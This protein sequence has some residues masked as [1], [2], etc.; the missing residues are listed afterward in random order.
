MY[1]YEL[2]KQNGRTAVKK[3]E[4]VSDLW[5]THRVWCHHHCCQLSVWQMSKFVFLRC[6]T[7]QS[8]IHWRPGCDAATER[9]GSPLQQVHTHTHTLWGKV[10]SQAGNQKLSLSRYFSDK[11]VSMLLWWTDDRPYRQKCSAC[12]SIALHA[13]FAY[14]DLVVEHK[15]RKISQVV[16]KNRVIKFVKLWRLHWVLN[17]WFPRVGEG[18]KVLDCLLSFEFSC[19]LSHTDFT[20]FPSLFFYYIAIISAEQ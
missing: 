2:Q 20:F 13:L 8:H 7:K 9:V 16:K 18:E 10:N 6:A 15:K 5:L 1:E 12:V 11:S 3:I 19:C 17:F 4:T 14:T